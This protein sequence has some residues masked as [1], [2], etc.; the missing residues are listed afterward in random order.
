MLN[1][2]AL[3]PAMFAKPNA[4]AFAAASENVRLRKALAG[5][6]TFHPST[7]A[8]AERKSA[9]SSK[10]TDSEINGR[11]VAPPGVWGWQSN[12]EPSMQKRTARI[13]CLFLDP[14]SDGSRHFKS[15]WAAHHPR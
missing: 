1:R 12:A 2:C 9:Q 13:L 8:A 10:R 6:P 5:T 15:P 7:A 3:K 4:S 14:W 11:I